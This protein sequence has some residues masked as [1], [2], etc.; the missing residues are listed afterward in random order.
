MFVSFQMVIT[1]P[2][3]CRET[4]PTAP[5]ASGS[6]SGAAA[7]VAARGVRG[8][9][10]G[11]LAPAGLTV[12]GRARPLNVEGAPQFGWLP[13]DTGP[14]EIQT[15]YRVRVFAAGGHGGGPRPVRDSGRVGSGRRSYVPYAG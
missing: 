13:R 15:A 14:G 4:A 8:G 1:E 2:G 7:P 3:A 12:G 10:R 9:G 6:A 5:T 11:P